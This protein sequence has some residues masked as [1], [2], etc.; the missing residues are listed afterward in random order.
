MEQG[1]VTISPPPP[2]CLKLILA[3][4]QEAELPLGSQVTELTSRC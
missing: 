4:L 2:K 1:L 3:Q